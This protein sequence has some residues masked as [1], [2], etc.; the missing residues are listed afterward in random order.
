MSCVLVALLL[1]VVGCNR[2]DSASPVIVAV[3]TDPH[4]SDESPAIVSGV[5]N[6]F[7]VSVFCELT[8]DG[9]QTQ[10]RW[11]IQRLGDAE[12]TEIRF[13]FSTSQGLEIFENFFAQ[14]PVLHTNMTI[15]FLNNSF[16][17]ANISCFS[18]NSIAI[19]GTF[20]VRIIS[21]SHHHI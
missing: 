5:E 7:N 10:T 19:N 4:T 3:A 13:S 8:S 2:A 11:Q 1:A 18:G 21:K 20:T 15:R 6:A 16:E 14:P 17:R 12:A 9:V